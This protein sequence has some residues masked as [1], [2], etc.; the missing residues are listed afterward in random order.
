MKVARIANNG[1]WP[2]SNFCPTDDRRL[3]RTEIR[4]ILPQGTPMFKFGHALKQA[5]D[6]D[7]GE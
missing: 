1:V 2:R 6:Q 3:E 7:G 4:S 5:P